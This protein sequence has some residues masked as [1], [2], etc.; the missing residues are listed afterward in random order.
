LLGAAFLLAKGSPQP[1]DAWE[2]VRPGVSE[3]GQAGEEHISWS[4]LSLAWGIIADIDLESEVLRCL[5]PLRMT[6]YGHHRLA[7][8]PHYFS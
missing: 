6:I 2:Y 3:G 7:I 4:M 5:G 1:L 8:E